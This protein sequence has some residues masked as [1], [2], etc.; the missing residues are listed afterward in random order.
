MRH[1]SLDIAMIGTTI[2][3]YTILEKLGEGGMG[4]VYKAE[5]T[6]LKRTVALKVLP[7]HSVGGEEEKA[8]FLRE[9]QA[10]AAIHHPNVCTVYEIDEYDG[11]MFL[12]MAYLEGQDLAHKLADGPLELKEAVD[13]AVQIAQGLQAAHDKNTVHR[14]VKP[15]NI[16]L[17]NEGQAVIMDFGL[18]HLPGTSRLTRAD[19]T[20]GT[21]AY[22][23][24][25]Q[26]SGAEIDHR[27]DLWSAG[28]VYYEMVSG[29]LPFWGEYEQAIMYSIFNEEPAPLSAPR[30]DIPDELRQ[31]VE[32]ILEKRP[33]QRYQTA[34]ELLSDLTSLKRIIEVP[35]LSLTAQTAVHPTAPSSFRQSSASRLRAAPSVAVLPLV[36]MSRDEENEYFADGVTEDIIS[37]LTK[38][39]SLRVAARNSAF[40]FKG[41]TPDTRE[42]GRKLKV[43]TVLS[44]SVRWAGN[45]LRVTVQLSSVSDGFEIWSE[46]YD[47]VMEDVF[48]IQDEISRA[49]VDKLKVELTGNA[50]EPIVGR[51]TESMEAY[52]LYLKGRHELRKL[53]R[54]GFHKSIEYYEQSI[55]ADA[56]YVQPYVGLGINYG[57]L[58]V[59]G[60]VPPKQVMPKAAGYANKA[61]QLDESSAEAHTLLAMYQHWYVWDFKGA[62]ESYQRALQLNPGEV[63]CLTMYALLMAVTE[64]RKEAISFAKRALQ[65]DPLSLDANRFVAYIYYLTRRYDEAAE[66]SRQLRQKEPNYFPATWTIG[67]VAAHKGDFDTAITAWRRARDLAGSDPISEAGLGWSL[68]I[69]GRTEEALS[70]LD[71]FKKRQGEQYFS[72]YSIAWV[73]LGLKDWDS[74]FEWLEKAYEEREGLIIQLAA[75]SLWDPLRDDPRF[76]DLLGRLGLPGSAA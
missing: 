5:D 39:G 42:V 28:V 15:A 48:E 62:E 7:P 53:T 57:Y 37:A 6:K 18:A 21:T 52:G 31:I 45:R 10:A 70:I 12:A 59:H 44:G 64:R 20:L 2:S 72:N 71:D 51:S 30:A 40:Q 66:L 46:R 11:R 54:E 69:A 32:K 29:K 76:R 16:M 22:M 75:E 4:V 36:N 47:R 35:E 9:A 50:E 8:R 38:L 65:W 68:G 33:E 56:N 1:S 55:E 34:A 3:H 27:S 19:S 58:A 43:D 14:D 63:E 73:Y 13:I 26:A 74:T 17:T 25:E 61:I 49:V 23:S 60:W 41:K 24:P 67:M